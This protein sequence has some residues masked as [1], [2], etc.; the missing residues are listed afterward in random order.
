MRTV[1]IHCDQCGK[2]IT[3]LPYEVWPIKIEISAGWMFQQFD[4][5]FCTWDCA[6]KWFAKEVKMRAT[7][8]NQP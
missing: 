2:D 6:S 8:E 7:V 3:E 4:G 1:T 5:E